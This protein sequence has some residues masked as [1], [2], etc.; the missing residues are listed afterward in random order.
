MGHLSY[1]CDKLL[2]NK[3]IVT[4]LQREHYDVIILDAF[5]PCSFILARKLG[6]VMSSI[7]QH[8]HPTIW[9]LFADGINLNM[10][11]FS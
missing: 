1:Q 11:M 9:Y 7:S 4:F 3:E 5:N 6:T 10:L 2:E 8:L